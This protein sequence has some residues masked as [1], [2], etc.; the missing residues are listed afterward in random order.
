MKKLLTIV[1]TLTFCASTLWAE[2]VTVN[3]YNASIQPVPKS[4]KLIIQTAGSTNTKAVENWWDGNGFINPFNQSETYGSITFTALEGTVLG[5][6]YFDIHPHFN[7]SWIGGYSPK[8][9]VNGGTEITINSSSMSPEQNNNY[10]SGSL[11]I[12]GKPDK[13]SIIGNSW[14]YPRF[15]NF[16]FTVVIPEVIDREVTTTTTLTK[17][18]NSDLDG[19]TISRIGYVPFVVKDPIDQTTPQNYFTATIKSG[20]TGESWTVLESG[21][22]CVENNDANRAQYNVENTTSNSKIILVPVQYTA[23]NKQNGTFSATVHLESKNIY[24]TN[25]DDQN[26]QITVGDVKQEYAISWGNSWVD[27]DEVDL[28]KGD[29]YPRTG[30]NGYLANT[31]GLTLGIPAIEV[32]EN[33]TGTSTLVSFAADGAMTLHE[34]GKVRLT[35]TQP[36]STTHNVKTLTLTVKIIKRTPEFTLKYDEKDGDAYVFYVNRDYNPFVTSSNEALADYPITIQHT[37][38]SNEQFISFD[39]PNATTYAVPMENIKITVSQA[40]G[41]LWYEGSATYSI[42]IREDPIHVGTLCDRTPAEI[43]LDDRCYM[44]GSLVAYDG[45]DILLG[46]TAGNT[47]GGWAVFKFEGTP[48]K[49]QWSYTTT[50]GS[51]TWTAEQSVDGSSFYALT[52]GDTFDEMARYLRLSISGEKAKGKITSLCITELVAAEI[53]TPDPIK[54]IDY[55]EPIGSFNVKV[56]NHT[57]LKLAL[58]DEYASDFILVCGEKSS[59]GTANNEI[60]LDYRE[61]LGIDRYAIVQVGVKFISE[62]PEDKLSRTTKVYLYDEQGNQVDVGNV[63]YEPSRTFYHYGPHVTIGGDSEDRADKGYVYADNGEAGS[64]DAVQNSQW[65]LEIYDTKVTEQVDDSTFSYTYY[66]KTE[67]SDKYA[68][69]GWAYTP[70]GEPIFNANPLTG[71]VFSATSANTADD[72]PYITPTLYAIFESYFYK[73]PPASFANMSEG[74]GS[75]AVALE[76]TNTP[77]WSNVDVNA[78]DALQQVAANQESHAYTVHYYAKKNVGSYFLGW[79]TTADGLNIIPG[80]TTEENGVYHYVPKNDY[81]TRAK[82]KNYP[83]VAAPL[84]AVFRSDIDIRQQD[85]MIVYIDDEGNGNINDAKVLIDFQKADNLTATLSGTDAS[86]FTL[87]NRSGSRSGKSI[88]FDATQG[89]IE[90]VVSYTDDNLRDAIGKKAE[91]TFSANYNGQEIT[92]SIVIVVEEAPVITFLPTDGK[93][94]YTVKMT[95]G[96]GVNYIMDKT[97]KENIKVAVTHESM[98]NIEM[99]LTEDVSGMDDKYYFFGWQ[100][101]DGEEITYLSYDELCTYQFTKSVKVRAQ[102]VHLNHATYFIKDDISNT[103]YS[104]LAS[105]L[106]DAAK[107][108]NSTGNSQVVVFNAKP[109]GTKITEGVLPKGNYTI[110]TGVTLLIPGDDTN[111]H[112]ETLEESDFTGTTNT[113]YVRWTVEKGTNIIVEG[114]AAFSIYATINPGGAS[115]QCGQPTCYGHV[116][117]GENVTMTFEN[118]SNLYAFGYITGSQTASVVMESG[119]T[120]K[121]IFRI[122]DWRGGT[123]TGLYLSSFKSSKVFIVGQYYVQNIEVP[124][125]I[126]PGAKEILTAG[127]KVDDSVTHTECTFISTNE[128]FFQLGTATTLTKYYNVDEDRLVFKVSQPEGTTEYAKLG[129]VSLTILI[130]GMSQ[131][132]DSKD[133][134]LPVPHNYDVIM[135]NNTKVQV[136]Y[137][138]AFMPGST[139]TI[140]QGST[141]E[142]KG[143]LYVYDQKC[144][145][146]NGIG[147]FGSGNSEFRPLTAR[148][149]GMQYVR[150]NKDFVDAK[151]LVNGVLDCTSGALYT[152]NSSSSTSDH[153]NITSNGG[154]KVK[155]GQ[156]GSKS[157]VHQAYQTSGGLLGQSVDMVDVPTAPARLL[158]ADATYQVPNA[159]T[160]Y[161][162]VNGTWTAGYNGGDQQPIIPEETSDIPVFT[163]SETYNF[164]TYVGEIHQINADIAAA[165]VNV[166]WSKVTWAYTLIGQDADQFSFAW[167]TKPAATVTFT[168]ESEGVKNAVLRVTATYRKPY[169]YDPTNTSKQHTHVYTKDIHLIGDASYWQTN[170][171]AFADLDVLYKGQNPIALFQAGSKNNNQPIIITTSAALVTISGNDNNAT[172]QASNI[173]EVTITA[174]Q[175]ADLANDIA[176]TTITKKVKVT[177]RVVWNWDILYFGTINENPISVLDGSTDW[178]LTEKEDKSNIIAYNS[179]NK[180][181]TIEDQIAGKYEVTFTFTQNGN[182]QD[183]KSVIIANPQHLRVDVNNDT[184]FRAV[185][186]SAN[187]NVS[188]YTNQTNA[189]NNC[190]RFKSSASSISQWKMTFIGIPDKLHFVPVGE[191]AWQIEES[192]NG[193]NWTTSFPWKKIT[194]NTDFEMSLLPSTRYLRISYG[195]SQDDEKPDPALK[196]FYITE[197][198][199]VKADVQELFMPFM[200]NEDNTQTAILAPKEIVLTYANTSILSVTTSN[201]TLFKVKKSSDSGEAGETFTIPATTEAN[202]FGI[203]GIEVVSHATSEEQ[204]YVYV[205]EGSNLVL[206]IPITTYAFPQQLPIKLASDK[207]DGGDRYYYVTTR[208]HNAQWDGTDGVRTITLNNAV[209]DADPYVTFAFRGNPTYISFDH[210]AVKGAFEIEQSI[211]GLDWVGVPH[212]VSNDIMDGTHLKRTVAPESNYL[213]I[214]YKSPYAEIISITNLVIVGDASVVIEPSLLELYDATPKAFTA[215]VVNLAGMKV[216]VTKGNFTVSTAEDGTYTSPIS[217]SKTQNPIL[218]GKQ[219]GDIPIYVKWNNT[220][221]VAIEYGMLE[222]TNPTK[223]NELMGTVELIGIKGEITSGVMGIYTGVHTGKAED[224]EV[225]TGA[226]EYTLKGSFEKEAKAYRKVNIGAAISA[227]GTPLFDYVVI[228]GETTTNDGN[229]TITTP[230]TMVG[231][232][233]KTPCYIYKKNEDGTAY[234]LAKRFE[235]ANAKE[236]TLLTGEDALNVEGSEKKVYITGFCPYASTGYTKADEGVWYFRGDAGGH[237]HVYLEDCFIYSRSKT[238]NGRAFADRGDGYSFVEPYVRGSGAVLVF[239]C[240]V[241]N[242]ITT[243]MNVTLHTLDRNI[244]KSHYGCFLQSVAGRAYQASSPVQVRVIDNTYILGS[245]VT[246]N[247]TDDWEAS[248]NSLTGKRTNGF[249]SLQ[250]QVNNAPSIDMGNGNTVVNFNG[251]QVELQNAQIVSPN[252]KSSLAICPRSGEFAGV[253][254][255]YGMGTDGVGG[256]VNFTDGTTTVIPMYVSPNY[257][258]SYL[259]DKDAE[260]NN[261]TNSRGEFLTT[262]LRTPAKTFVSGGSHCMMRACS[263]PESQGG[264][265]KNK[266]G[267]DG[268]LLGLYKYPRLDPNP[269]DAT[270]KTLNWGWDDIAGGNGLVTPKSVP[271]GYGILSVTPN[272]NGTESTEDDYLNFWFDPA[273]ESTVTPEIDKQISFWKTCMTLIEAQYAGEGGS[274]GGD[275]TIKFEG[276]EQMELIKYLLYCKIDEHILDE[277]SSGDYQAP[278]KNPAPEGGNYLPIHPSKVGDQTQHFFTNDESFQVEGKL[279]YITTATADVWNAFTAPFDVA[280]IYIMETYPENELEKL[281]YRGGKNRTEILKVQAKHNADFA[282]FFGVTIALKQ[283]KVFETIYSEYMAWADAQD[284]ELGLTQDRGYT[285]RGKRLLVPYNGVNWAT[286][287]FYLNENLTDAGE[288]APWALI[289]AENDMFKTTWR[290]PDASDGILLHQGVTYSMLLP[291]CTGCAEVGDDGSTIQRE[292]WDYWSGKF[293]IFE[294]TEGTATHPHVIQGKSILDEYNEEGIFAN[295]QTEEGAVLMGNSTLAEM[296]T[297]NEDLYTYSGDIKQSTFRPIELVYDEVTG[298]PIHASIAP[299]ESFLIPKFPNGVR[300]KGIT[301]EGNIIYDDNNSNQNGTTGGNMPTV[302]GGNDLFVTSIAGG[303]NVAVAAPQNVRVL[304]STGAVIY[305]GYIQTAVDVKLPTNGIYIVS[306]ENEVQKILY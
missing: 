278:V 128:G 289:D 63:L 61:G 24:N 53:I 25:N 273:F 276:E 18:Q 213:R 69:K 189:D 10:N 12:E 73:T 170:T 139:F 154:G 19:G 80:S 174:S 68:F 121:E 173:G 201:T 130:L 203:T 249:L 181:A 191:G 50:D 31:S 225:I 116:L 55:A 235:N 294:S 292:F 126:K 97:V 194:P 23:T 177:E 51:G 144:S 258:E 233:A 253:L 71:C 145:T 32:L 9:K 279:Y 91:I 243:P 250:K 226:T 282:S 66:A 93:G 37:D 209:S 180:T 165:N 123:A 41:D 57:S 265:P 117:L 85:R 221:D 148:P 74:L 106:T 212:N 208:T 133:F 168:P 45:N 267:E 43:L 172:I 8:Y 169:D 134:V 29:I 92:R 56:S 113:E 199:H 284:K 193:V 150:T 270:N 200:V 229:T 277:I 210:T 161:T 15:K 264:A 298:D 7:S 187:D 206:Q 211:D 26:V 175:E 263:D 195:A 244:L 287:D 75:I 300:A 234:T 111:R 49:L 176:A 78:S 207:P 143:S 157:Q 107:L 4:H 99:H 86:L 260:G 185:T 280:N 149:G 48:N 87:S 44:G 188:F 186:L 137:D 79:S 217:L 259:L 141:C 158:N 301:L 239:A 297:I 227:S 296:K 35:Y 272:T 305:S 36:G 205:Y 215:S 274:V 304:S 103:P 140:N 163:A 105:A 223:N 246:L 64:I 286:A 256:T 94:T 197:L 275:A 214:L 230:T 281:E 242:N 156:L 129:N 20:A 70:Y 114:G 11:I 293:L 231:S 268:V 202:P 52:D 142:L 125:I 147:Y 122:T 247:F 81:I 190:V 269:A 34:I 83:H 21:W 102:F 218:D 216:T 248:K 295:Q 58:K 72:N 27:G 155:F 42:A 245:A 299:T 40:S 224:G 2:Q 104:D 5:T 192:T 288:K 109:Q 241:Q 112:V 162:Y 6:Y 219:M 47:N 14:G 266:P 220:S 22:S 228:Y 39:A 96:S 261:I 160:T 38:A 60:T 136:L 98:S 238:D 290:Y 178:T 89:L 254:L 62:K 182:S 252:Y 46:S 184:V 84:Y 151:L 120:V 135:E 54:V 101:I 171:L 146:L 164:S 90:M 33:P 222:V 131:T 95:N 138:F 167:G 76:V 152:T 118:G 100:M 115:A 88:T 166:D 28:F 255:A 198:A 82:D 77:T 1:V 183:F 124:L 303:I 251:G 236:K 237:I 271:K 67:Q 196:D 17:L 306:G 240:N 302:G 285:R 283:N 65:A 13:A 3:L 127:I 108:K 132:V 257:A 16:E 204:G 119:S 291:F 262:C 110:P 30:S 232:N 153:A 179:T 159:N 59:Q